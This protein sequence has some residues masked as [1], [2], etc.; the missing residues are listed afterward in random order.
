MLLY[1][2]KNSVFTEKN[3]SNLQDFMRQAVLPPDT[4]KAYRKR[5]T[6]SSSLPADISDRHGFFKQNTK[7]FNHGEKETGA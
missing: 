3:E 5:S 6:A 4:V 2:K 1:Q 7:R